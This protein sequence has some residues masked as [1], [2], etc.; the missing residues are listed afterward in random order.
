[1]A[2]KRQPAKPRKRRRAPPKSAAASHAVEAPGLARGP[3]KKRPP[4]GIPV[5]LSGHKTRSLWFRARVS[6]PL[7]DADSAHL[8]SERARVPPAPRPAAPSWAQV[9]PTNIGGRATAL[10]VDPRDARRVWLGAAG[11]GVWYS[12]DGGGNWTAQW[13]NEPVLNVGALAIDGADGNV[14]YCGTGEANLSADSYPGVGLF[15]TGDGGNTWRLIADARRNEVP[16]RIGTIAIDPFDSAHVLLGGIGYGNQSPGRDV[17]GLYA[18][19]NGGAAWKRHAQLVAGNYW[20]H[21]VAFDPSRRGVVFA[22]VTARGSASGIYRSSDG[23]TTWE[24]LTAGLPPSERFGRVALAISPSKPSVIYALAADALSQSGDKLLGVFRSIDGGTK[25]ANISGEHLAGEGQMSYGCAIVVH[26]TSPNHVLCGGVDLHRTTDG[27]KTWARA[28]RWDAT[29]GTAAYAHA[30]HHALLMPASPAGLVYDA[31]DGGLDV[32]SDGGMDWVNRSNGLATNMF[33]DF[34]VAQGQAS[35]FGGGAQDNGTLVTQKGQADEYEQ[36]LGGD[37]GWIVFDPA[38]ARHVYASYYNF[39]IF[40]FKDG[41]VKNVSPKGGPGEAESVWMVYITLDP[42]NSSTVFTGT[43]RVWRTRS[44][45]EQWSAVSAELDGSPISAIEVAPAD[46]KV[47]YVGTENGGIFRSVDGGGTWSANV[48]GSVLPGLIVTRIDTHPA[49]ARRVFVT[50]G[51]T[52]ASH[53]FLSTDGGTSWRDIDQHRLPDVPHNAVLVRPDS[54]NEIYV[55]NDVGVFLTTDLGASW[56]NVSDN[57][58]STMIV[59]LVFRL[60]DRR[61]FAATYG[62]STWARTLS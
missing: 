17:G 31:N 58:P 23:A 28:S 37:G 51:G 34:D 38:D 50:G 40:R 27:G 15:K 12:A 33:Y 62:R 3:G 18:S 39:N 13:H 25:W 32:S 22:A 14:L 60:S 52:H 30:D 29:R 54:P 11:G 4:H 35:V 44:D 61:L 16:T 8:V 53:V 20:C 7:R 48:A 41:R 49:D 10:A 47:I 5:R 6:W 45:G 56:R 59:D 46:S 57:L 21:A 55:G 42:N 43:K 2:K 26:P 36:L 24:H 9:G 19:T 1:M